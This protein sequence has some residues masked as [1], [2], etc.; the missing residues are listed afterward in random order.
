MP[1][2]ANWIASVIQNIQEAA[3][4]AQDN[5]LLMRAFK[6]SAIL[7]CC[8]CEFNACFLQVAQCARIVLVPPCLDFRLISRNEL[9]PTMARRFREEACMI[10]INFNVTYYYIKTHV[11]NVHIS[12]ITITSDRATVARIA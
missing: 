4:S 2:S 6:V 8:D 7:L 10:L 1:I 3:K 5:L 11:A 12:V 9:W